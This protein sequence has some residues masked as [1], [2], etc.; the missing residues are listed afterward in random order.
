[1]G[2]EQEYGGA[3]SYYLDIQALAS[4]VRSKRGARGLRVIAQECRTSASTI[5]RVEREQVPDISSFLLLCD[6]LEISPA[7]LFKDSAMEEQQGEGELPMSKADELALRVRANS[8]LEPATAN[9]LAVLI[10]AAYKISSEV[11]D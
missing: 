3:V 8:R 10:K 9:I 7:R 11:S 5:S 2:S 1:M 6:W 4:L